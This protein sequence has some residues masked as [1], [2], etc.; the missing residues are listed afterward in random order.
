MN[1]K[2]KTRANQT[3]LVKQCAA[4]GIVSRGLC[5]KCYYAAR[6]LIREGKTSW[7]ELQ[8]LGLARATH[9]K[10]AESPLAVAFTKAKA[11]AQVAQARKRTK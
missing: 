4:V 3:C 5:Q 11:T 1:A 8:K 2:T 9:A 10:L 6:Y 7:E